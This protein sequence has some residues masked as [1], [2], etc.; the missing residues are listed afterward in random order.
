MFNVQCLM[1]DVRRRAAAATLIVLLFAGGAVFADSPSV[2]AVLSNSEAAVGETVELQ[3]KV[4]GAGA[5]APGEIAVDGLEIHQTGTEQH[6]EVNNFNVSQSVIYNYTVLP[7]KTG[8]FKIPP[9]TVDVGGKTLRTPELV[10]NVTN[11]SGRSGQSNPNAAQASTLDPRKV[12]F[13]E[14][15][16]PKQQA[17]VGE[18]IP[19]VVKLCLNPRV[20]FQQIEPPEIDAQG[21]T[22]QK[23]QKSG[24]NMETIGGATYA[25]TTFKTALAAARAGKFDIPA[26]EAKAQALLPRSGSSSR[27]IPRRRSPFDLFNLD[28]SNDPLF[29]DLAV[30]EPRRITLR[31]EPATLEVKPLPPKAPA[32]FSGAVGSFTLTTDA[33]PKSVQVGDP[34]TVRSTITG[35]GNFDRVSAPALEDERGWHTY[36][37]SSKFNKDDDVGISGAKI[38]ESVLSPN[39]KKQ[40]V[41]ALAFS[42]FDPAKEQYVTLR[43]EPIPVK[44]EGTALQAAAPLP[45]ASALPSQ[46]ASKPAAAATK[47]QDILY[48]L[49]DFGRAQ[50]F[51]PLYV[52]P[53]FWM[54]QLI[55]LLALFGFAGWKIRQAKIDNREAQRT[56][57]LHH[58]AGQLMRKL[59]RDDASPAEY[60]S[61]ASRAVQIK[62]ALARNVD[63]NA[64]DAEVATKTF[65][66]DESSREQLRRLFA[67]SD[68]LRYSGAKNGTGAITSQDR[69]DVLELIENLRT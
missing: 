12:G 53:L 17:Y 21:L 9:Q 58:E 25:V 8:K 69:H 42:Y 24:E 44:V 1:S 40:A 32:N 4:A 39:E 43:S 14:L 6:Y 13:I 54:G 67:R 31:S 68:E 51:T 61:Q 65:G 64:V 2:T 18:I 50:S 37:P 5:K 45:A 3:I 30:L 23:L 41:P 22:T 47:P 63:P 15:I 28:P 7:M 59:R 57:A 35:R 34:I 48:Q 62:T 66:L 20:R 33:N 38:F 52:R 36:P 11:S 56:A 46:T 29:G 16:M 26:L 27:N 60:F 55:P 19:V 10:L 49:T